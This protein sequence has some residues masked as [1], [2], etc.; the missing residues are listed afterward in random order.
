MAVWWARSEAKISGLRPCLLSKYF[1]SELEYRSG[2]NP[3]LLRGVTEALEGLKETETG[4]DLEATLW[5]RIG[6][7]QHWRLVEDQIFKFVMDAKLSGGDWVA[8][9]GLPQTVSECHSGTYPSYTVFLT[10]P[11]AL[12]AMEA[13][14]QHTT[15]FPGGIEA[16]DGRHFQVMEDYTIKAASGHIQAIAARCLR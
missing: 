4:S 11:S 6:K 13:E 9:Y 15:M 7:N 2:N 14:I 3:L 12:R 5:S 10:A 16:V 8:R 1:E